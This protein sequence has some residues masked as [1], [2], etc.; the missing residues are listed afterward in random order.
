MAYCPTCGSSLTAGVKFCSKCGKGVS[1]QPAAPAAGTPPAATSQGSGT[2]AKILWTILTLILLFILAAMGSC[3]YIAYRAKKKAE[4][5]AQTYKHSDAAGIVQAIT[6]KVTGN[7]P[8]NFRIGSWPLLIWLLLLQ[9]RFR[10]AH[11]CAW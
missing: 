5:I 4:E 7:N 3:V 10:S 2:P 6:G 11:P 8:R 9:V 1:E